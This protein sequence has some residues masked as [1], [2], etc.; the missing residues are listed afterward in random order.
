MPK[1]LSALMREVSVKGGLRER[2]SERVSER[3]MDEK[4]LCPRP[5]RMQKLELGTSS[6]INL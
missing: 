3:E 6:Q 5:K 1:T 4:A 2:V